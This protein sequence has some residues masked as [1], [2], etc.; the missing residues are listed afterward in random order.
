MTVNYSHKRAKDYASWTDTTGTYE[1]IPFTDDGHRQHL[2]HLP[3]DERP[4]GSRSSRS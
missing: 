4:G 2:R 1:R 3:A